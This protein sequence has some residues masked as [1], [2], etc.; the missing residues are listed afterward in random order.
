[1]SAPTPRLRTRNSSMAPPPVA[2]P[3]TRSRKTSTVAPATEAV[4]ASQGKTTRST[5]RSN[6][7]TSKPLWNSAKLNAPEG[8]TGGSRP[9]SALAQ[10]ARPKTAG[11]AASRE[12]SVSGTGR[13]SVAYDGRVGAQGEAATEPIQVS[14]ARDL[15]C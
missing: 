6:P 10:H 9:S 3:T 5:A 1:M 14:H 13:E 12:S 11:A 7:S 4:P 15:R 2:P 8:A